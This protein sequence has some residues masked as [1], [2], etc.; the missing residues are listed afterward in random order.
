MNIKEILKNMQYNKL[1][2]RKISGQT[3]LLVLNASI[4]AAGAGKSGK[5]FSVVVDEVKKLAEQTKVSAKEIIF[6]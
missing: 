1:L 5:G 4:E 2:V 6:I 3:N